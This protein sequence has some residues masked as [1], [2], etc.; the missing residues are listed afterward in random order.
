[1]GTTSRASDNDGLG[2]SLVNV[3][4]IVTACLDAAEA[5][6]VVEVGAYRGELTAELLEWAR[7][8]DARVTA[9]EPDP[10]PAL[11]ELCRRHPELGL[12]EQTSHDAL[13]DL[14][15]PDALIV[16][17]DHNYYT[18]TEELRLIFEKAAGAD[19]PLVMFHDVAWPHA[20]RDTYHA[21]EQIP[22]EHRQP[23]ARNVGLAPGEPG[24]GEFGVPFKWAA[25]RE[26][27]PRNGV[28]TAIEDFTEGR[29][30]LRLA[31]I[32][33]FFGIGV[34]WHRDAP[35]A[36]A[37]AAIVDPWDRN[38]ILERLE[39]NRVAHLAADI[40]NARELESMQERRAEQER[41]LMAMLGSSAFA[42]AE[43]LARLRQRG[44]LTYSRAQVKRALGL[45]DDD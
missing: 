2:Y 34:L 32:P 43:R 13:R 4:E 14:P 30:G 36:G 23:L 5:R 44:P 37:V 41:L 31:T 17:G 18:L 19:S 7:T 6:S 16:D 42:I 33:A 29:E 28:L 12:I 21:P 26:G 40:R 15:L 3:I 20:R 1:M 24:V 10:P 11:V 22:A 8:A 39:A 45:T 25:Q 35:W 27:G 38:P 9:I